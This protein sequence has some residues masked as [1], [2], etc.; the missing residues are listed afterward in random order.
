MRRAN[1]FILSAFAIVVAVWMTAQ[2]ASAQS[3]E[4]EA[5]LFPIVWQENE[6]S[7]RARG[8]DTWGP[9]NLELWAFRNGSFEF[10]A[11]TL[12][13]ASGEFDFGE[14]AAP[15]QN[16]YLTVTPAGTHPTVKRLVR[17]ERPVQAPIITVSLGTAPIELIIQPARF[18]GEFRFRDGETNRLLA[19]FAIDSR[20]G[21]STVIDLLELLGPNMPHEIRIEQVL[22][23]G[24]VSASAFYRFDVPAPFD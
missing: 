17:V 18:E 5:K 7:L 16:L 21:Q 23:D 4:F 9:R 6:S 14:I 13:S 10:I 12:S 8:S 2:S 11:A 1:Q 15:Q 24:R 22:E 19:R 3:K 20:R